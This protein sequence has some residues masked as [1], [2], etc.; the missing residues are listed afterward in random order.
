MEIRPANDEMVEGYMDGRNPD[1]PEPSANRSAS[2]R[3]GFGSGRADLGAPPRGTFNEVLKMA[4]DAMNADEALAGTPSL[5][6]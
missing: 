2:Y 6:P 1:N 4:E 5:S 3:H